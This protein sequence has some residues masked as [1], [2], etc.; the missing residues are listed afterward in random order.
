M[1]KTLLG[2]LTPDLITSDDMTKPHP[3]N[4]YSFKIFISKINNNNQD[5]K[6]IQKSLTKLKAFPKN[7][8]IINIDDF[9]RELVNNY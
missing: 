6:L 2:I 5:L 8:L 4:L 9:I 7:D 1:K 3:L